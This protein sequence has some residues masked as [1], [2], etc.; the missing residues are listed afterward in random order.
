MIATHV[1]LHAVGLFTYPGATL[2]NPEL[3]NIAEYLT[4]DFEHPGHPQYHGK[5]DGRRDDL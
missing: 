5:R 1:G 4:P 3:D 2:H